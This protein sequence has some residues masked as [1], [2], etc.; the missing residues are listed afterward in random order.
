MPEEPLT[1]ERDEEPRALNLAP[2]PTVLEEAGA[3][4]YGGDREADYGGPRPSCENIA[5]LW[6]TY[7]HGAGVLPH[8]VVLTAEDAACCLLLLKVSRFA[9]GGVKRDT[10][11]DMAGYAAVI[12]RVAGIDP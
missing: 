5:A 2:A 9:T 3:L 12:A 1:A 8:E 6:T 7:L 10:I 11:V 4:V